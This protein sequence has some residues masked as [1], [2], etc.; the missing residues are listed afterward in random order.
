[1]RDMSQKQQRIAARIH[2]VLA[3]A[4]SLGQLHGVAQTGYIITLS[5]VWVSSDA[6]VATVYFTAIGGTEQAQQ[7]AQ[8]AL[9]A[10]AIT[11]QKLIAR[12]IKT[13]ATPK[14]TFV[15]DDRFDKA[16]ALDAL[17]KKKS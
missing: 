10:E 11:A 7:Q 6:K 12:H 9:Q 14:L 2:E 16:D 1:M 17:L 15:Y 13:F 4:I 3:R 5:D 8:E